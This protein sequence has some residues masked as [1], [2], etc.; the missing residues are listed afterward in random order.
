MSVGKT[1]SASI[2]E[3]VA[4]TKFFRILA[5]YGADSSV[6]RLTSSEPFPVIA[7]AQFRLSEALRRIEVTPGVNA[8]RV[9]S[10]GF[11]HSVHRTTMADAN[12]SG[13]RPTW[14]DL[15]AV[16]IW[17]SRKLHLHEDLGLELKNTAYALDASTINPCLT[18]VEWAAFRDARAEVMSHTVLDILVLESGV[19]YVMGRG[20]LDFVRLSQ[21]HQAGA[22]FFLTR[23]QSNMKVRRVYSAKLDR[24]SGILCDQSIALNGYYSAQDCPEHLRRIKIFLDSSANVAKT[25][26]SFAVLTYVRITVFK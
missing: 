21:M 22:F 11:R 12:Y 18:L 5:R 25:K 19:S 6:C 7:I 13:Y 4:W 14:S 15:A 1:L 20:H 8:S 24:S 2:M 9:Y 16:L 23:P 10:M 3:L 26:I 17:H